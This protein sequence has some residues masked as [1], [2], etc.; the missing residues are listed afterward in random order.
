M[1][2]DAEPGAGHA[3]DQGVLHGARVLAGCDAGAVAEAEDVGVHGHGV[4]AEGD[5]EHDVG[6]LA[7]DAGQGFQVLA[8]ARHLAAVALDQELREGD[9]VAGLG[10]PEADGADVPGDAFLAER[11]HGRRVRCCSEQGLHGAVD[12]GV[13]GLGGEHDGDEQRV[14]VGEVQLARGVGVEAGEV[15]EEGL[16]LGDGHGRCGRHGRRM[17]ALGQGDKRGCTFHVNGVE[18]VHFEA[19]ITPHR[20]LGRRGLIVLGG[21]IVLLS[22]VISAGLWWVGAWPALGI[23]AV[24]ILLALL[25]LRWN[26]R[27]RRACELLLLSDS[28]LR[29]VRTDVRGRRQELV[30]PAV[31]LRVLLQERQGQTPA[32]LLLARGAR[33]EVA[34]ALG[35]AEKRDLAWALRD[36]LD[37]WRHPVFDNPQ[38]RES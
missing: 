38:L 12:G 17:L 2:R 8:L 3:L 20:S 33:L 19:V 11:H 14:G 21:A 23:N 25:L 37:R 24:E 34:Q 7:A 32:L 27:Q 10:A 1:V 16:D 30:L 5:A 31:W 15:F 29:V 28:G 13:R 6:G 36:A 18:R 35:E 26:A 22:G 4:L 9:D